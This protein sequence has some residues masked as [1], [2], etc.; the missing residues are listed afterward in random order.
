MWN[1][2]FNSGYQMV[3]MLEDNFQ[4]RWCRLPAKQEQR[5]AIAYLPQSV[6]SLRFW[7]SGKGKIDH[8]YLRCLVT[9]AADTSKGII[10]VN[11]GQ[12][13]DYYLELLG[14]D[15]TKRTSRK[16]AIDDGDGDFPDAKRHRGQALE[17]V[18]GEV[19]ALEDSLEEAVGALLDDEGIQGVLD[20]NVNDEH[21]DELAD[22]I[23]DGLEDDEQNID[24]GDEQNIDP[25]DDFPDGPEDVKA[26]NHRWGAF[27][28]TMKRA[29]EHN[30]V[31]YSWQCS[32]PFHKKNDGTGCK[33]SKTLTREQSLSFEGESER[34]LD[35]L[36][37]WATGAL[38]YARQRRHRKWEV[39][40]DNC[41]PT[42]VIMAQIIQDRPDP[43]TIRTDVEL[44]AEEGIDPDDELEGGDPGDDTHTRSSVTIQYDV[45]IIHISYGF[46]T[47]MM[48]LQGL[49]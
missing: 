44:D 29:E 18:D 9:A 25:G 30:R 23:D 37:H 14:L 35:C 46:V 24:L 4:F 22:D 12:P 11:H 27:T 10:E 6:D 20:A 42:E 28:F 21:M 33:K 17:D 31:S 43:K 26:Y 49:L 3:L 48:F 7:C 36:R 41:P 19:L 2:L 40:N 13:R 45:C 34:V 47:R 16:L 8:M 5:I 32:C 1:S 38:R 15:A 39:D